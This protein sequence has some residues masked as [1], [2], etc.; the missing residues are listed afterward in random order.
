MIRRL[1]DPLLFCGYYFRKIGEVDIGVAWYFQP[2]YFTC[3]V[4]GKR[5]SDLVGWMTGLVTV[6]IEKER[7]DN[8]DDGVEYSCECAD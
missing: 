1:V 3:G 5:G 2:A 4:A 7:E 6:V 8:D